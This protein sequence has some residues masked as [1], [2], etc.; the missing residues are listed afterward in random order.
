MKIAIIA[1]LAAL[2]MLSC[3]EESSAPTPTAKKPMP[4]GL[5]DDSVRITS[6][7]PNPSG[8]DESLEWFTVTN[9][10]SKPVDLFSGWLVMDIERTQSGDDFPL[11]FNFTG[12]TLLPYDSLKVLN[13]SKKPFMR[14]SGDSLILYNPTTKL[15]QIAAYGNAADDKVFYIK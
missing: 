4:F 13:A 3:K 15:V 9:F 7:M 12:E 2:T 10:S 1:L 8:S 14:N 11:G 5:T 6:I